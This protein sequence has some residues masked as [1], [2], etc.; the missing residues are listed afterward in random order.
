VSEQQQQKL[1]LTQISCRFSSI[2]LT[3]M[4]NTVYILR[5]CHAMQLH[6]LSLS[7][8]LLSTLTVQQQLTEIPV[9]AESVVFCHLVIGKMGTLFLWNLVWWSG[10]IRWTLWHLPHTGPPTSTAIS[11]VFVDHW[12]C[13]LTDRESPGLKIS[14][15]GN[16]ILCVVLDN[17][18][19]T[20][21]H[22]STEY[23]HVY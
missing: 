13:I 17:I 15:V 8:G 3:F 7:L 5:C 21:T 22:V 14:M 18:V 2:Y 1:Q 23:C 6:L 9:T 4:M 11:L 16:I 10:Y 12:C 19:L 20:C